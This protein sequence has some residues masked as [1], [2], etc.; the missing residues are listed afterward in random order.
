[1]KNKLI[2]KIEN[3]ALS[4]RGGASF[5]VY[6][7]WQD[8]SKSLKNNKEAYFIINGAEG[9][10][11]VKK[12]EYILEKYLDELINGIYIIDKYF[13]SKKIKKIYFYLNNNYLKKFKKNILK[14]LKEDKYKNIKNKIEFFVKVENP[15]YISGEESTI[16]NIIEGKRTTPRLKPPYPST[17]G[18]FGKPTLIHNIETIY[19][20]SLVSKNKYYGLRFY[21]INGS[22]KKPGVYNFSSDMSI[23]EVLRESGNYP[24]FNFFVQ[25]GGQASGEVLNKEQLFI[26]AFSAASI[27]VYDKEKTNQDK[28]IKYW[29]KFYQKE[30][31]GN[32]SICREGTYRLLEM[33]NNPPYDEELFW[34]IVESLENSSLCALG[35][36]L[37][38]PLK[39]YYKNIININK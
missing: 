25:I 37:S 13:S 32:C 35:S 33:I 15:G 22:V 5:P 7:K 38:I 31:C 23:G 20:I 4:G 19:D 14:T 10:P 36:S 29:L 39:S 3:A 24:D 26:P 1:M 16:L 21:Y 17:Q 8:F 34:D 27:M 28:L 12:D 2:D 30:S 11:G 6:W 18:L 9:E